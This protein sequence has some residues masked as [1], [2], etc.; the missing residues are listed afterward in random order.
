VLAPHLPALLRPEGLVYVES[1][2]PFVAVPPLEIRRQGRAGA[3][4]YALAGY[5]VLD[6]PLPGA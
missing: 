4:H 1:E 2:R 5:R 3:V 6:D